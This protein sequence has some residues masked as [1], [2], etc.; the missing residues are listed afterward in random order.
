MDTHLGSTIRA[1]DRQGAL[2]VF[3]IGK[4]GCG[5]GTQARLLSARTGWAVISAGQQFRD[6]A[7]LDTKVGRK[8]KSEIEAG[9]LAPHW[10]AMY[11][12]Q[13]A[14]FSLPND[15]S[16][17]FDGFNRTLPE[18]ELILESLSWLERPFS[19]FDIRVS[20]EEVRRRLM[21][22]KETEGR[23]D[24]TVVNERL[25]EYDA[26]TEPAVET[27]RRAGVLVEIQGEQSP[28]KVAEDIR[29]A[30]ALV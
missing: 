3:F 12:F 5:K 22:R 28:E 13:K 19:I 25:K 9:L 30:L 4:P 15:V 7:A 14:L 27:F 29:T 2:T 11:L 8:I 1:T 24:D 26:Y 21:A 20:D 18:A 23:Q 16:V 10:F 17:I 6:I